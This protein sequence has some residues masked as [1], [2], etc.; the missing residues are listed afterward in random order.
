[1]K[2]QKD[3]PRTCEG[4]VLQTQYLKMKGE[5]NNVPPNRTGWFRAG[6]YEHKKEPAYIDLCLLLIRHTAGSL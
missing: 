1:M 6:K 4:W 5:F 3:P 2:T